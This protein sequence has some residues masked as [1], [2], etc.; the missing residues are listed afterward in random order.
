MKKIKGN[1]LQEQVVGKTLQDQILG[2]IEQKPKKRT[3]TSLY[4]SEKLLKD[5][6]AHS[7]RNGVAMSVV[8]E[9][10]ITKYLNG[11]S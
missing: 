3:K 8:L 6:K 7:K 10:L 4:L 11:E 2:E 5:L 1:T 9:K